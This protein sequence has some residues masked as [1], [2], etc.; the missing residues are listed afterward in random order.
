MGE[1]PAASPV[2]GSIEGM[3]A[4]PD[5][6]APASEDGASGAVSALDR[7]SIGRIDIDDGTLIWRDKAS[8]REER[9]EALNLEIKVPKLDG[10]GT[11]EG[12]FTRLGVENDLALTIGARRGGLLQS[13]IA[14]PLTIPLLIFASGQGTSLFLA[15]MMLASLPLSCWIGAALIRASQD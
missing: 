8:N 14:L 9:I 3:I 1:A 13:L 12:S 2:P 11:V 15:A 10:A 6:A 7:L 5:A 4:A